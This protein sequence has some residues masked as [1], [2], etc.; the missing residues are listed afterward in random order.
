MKKTLTKFLLATFLLSMPVFIEARPSV[1]SESPTTLNGAEYKQTAGVGR[2]RTHRRVRRRV[3]RRHAR[4][5]VRRQYRVVR[6]R[7]VR[8]RARGHM[9]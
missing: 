1:E 7:P 5:Y 8:R 3:R 4:R 6:R 9:H 2:I